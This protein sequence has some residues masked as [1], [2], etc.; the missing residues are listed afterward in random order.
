MAVVP[1]GIGTDGAKVYVDLSWASTILAGAT[2]T[3]KSN[4][5]YV[6]LGGA[7]RDPATVVCGIDPS[8]LLLGP[9]SDAG[10]P[11]IVLGTAN[12]AAVAETLERIVQVMDGRIAMLRRLG[13]DKLVAS[14]EIPTVLVVLEEWAGTLRACKTHDATA[15]PADRL[16]PRVEAAV[17][18]LLME[19]SKCGVQAFCLIQ[20]A[21]AALLGGDIRAQYARRICHRLDNRDGMV[22]LLPDVEKDAVDRLMA[23]KP[24]VGLLAEAGEPPRWFRSVRI[25]Y[26]DYLA[27][28]RSHYQPRQLDA[29]TVADGQEVS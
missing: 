23:A 15:K 19:G 1:F 10:Q 20:R 28:V 21:D 12:P 17:G 27:C 26:G 3:G 16:L 24:G 5:S 7:S 9:F 8:S 4:T 2:R 11:D 6:L 22:M 13:V 29:S 18:R 25:E 14:V